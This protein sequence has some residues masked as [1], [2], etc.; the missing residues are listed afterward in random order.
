MN[1][2]PN[3][4]EIRQMLIQLHDQLAQAQAEGIDENDQALLRHLMGDIQEMLN[5]AEHDSQARYPAN[6]SIAE[7]MEA[8]ITRLEIS[9]PTLSSMIRKALDTLDI[10]GI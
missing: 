7:R 4:T 8:A 1:D 2:Q 9:H 6:P 5:R 10:A 3:K